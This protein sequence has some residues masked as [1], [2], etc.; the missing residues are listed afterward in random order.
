M[1]VSFGV[2]R[3]GPHPLLA[4]MWVGYWDEEVVVVREV[5]GGYLG[6]LGGSQIISVV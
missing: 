3:G 1:C 6:H 5:I 4:Q 2:V